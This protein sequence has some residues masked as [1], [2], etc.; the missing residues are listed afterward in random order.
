M[1]SSAMKQ[2]KFYDSLGSFQLED[3]A[4]DLLSLVE[5]TA[6]QMRTLLEGLLQQLSRSLKIGTLECGVKAVRGELTV[7]LDDLCQ[8]LPNVIQLNL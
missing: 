3:K 7:T 1:N 6:E 8:V 4:K 5:L 2:V